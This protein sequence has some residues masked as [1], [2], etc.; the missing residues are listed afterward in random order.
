MIIFINLSGTIKEQNGKKRLI[1]EK[2]DYYQSQI[3]QYPP[4][5]KVE[6]LIESKSGKRSNQ[7]NRYWHGVCFPVWAEILGDFNEVEAKAYCREKFIPV[8]TKKAKNGQTIEIKLGTSDLNSYEGWEFTQKMIKNAS[9]HGHYIL[10]PCEAGYNCGR[11]ECPTC[12]ELMKKDELPYPEDNNDP[13]KI[14]W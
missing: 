8:K 1:F 4:E 9:L 11:K 2:P 14:P 7:Q 13:E 10:T 12:G 5:T 3:E 6:I